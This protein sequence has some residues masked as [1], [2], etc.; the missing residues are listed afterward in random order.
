MEKYLKSLVMKI[1]V[2]VSFDPPYLYVVSDTLKHLIDTF[3]FRLLSFAF[4]FL[5][6]TF[7]LE[8]LLLP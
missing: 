2:P 7:D 6:S 4:R 8:N 3:V 1:L 5:L